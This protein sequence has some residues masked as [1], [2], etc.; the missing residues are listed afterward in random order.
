MEIIEELEP[1]RRSA[2][3][4]SIGYI[5]RHG[6]MDTS[7]TIRT[8]IAENNQIY[9]WA[10]GGLVADSENDAEYQETLDKLCRILPVL[11]S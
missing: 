3:C 10:G 8:L 7:I 11:Q 2:Y 4:G 9:V 5:S 6:A 1:H